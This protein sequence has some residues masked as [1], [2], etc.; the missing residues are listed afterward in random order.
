MAG[1]L[2]R[3]GLLLALVP[4]AVTIKHTAANAAA[5]QFL[6]SYAANADSN[7]LPSGLMYKILNAGTG[8]KPSAST[9]CQ[10]HYEGRLSSNYPSGPVFDSS[11]K[12]GSPS[13]FAPNQVIKGWTEAMQMMPVG[14]KWELVCP[15]EI[16]Y[17]GR[18]MGSKIPANSVLVFTMELISCKGVHSGSGAKLPGGQSVE[19]VGTEPRGYQG[20]ALGSWFALVSII[21]ACVL[22]VALCV[23]F[24]GFQGKPR[25]GHSRHGG[26]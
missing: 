8:G 19:P 18:S 12:R 23:V 5:K 4:C 26:G 7:E 17:G 16:A 22:V 1:V 25:A 20:N 14:S 10:C 24:G 13:S 15:P 9:S 6:E 21:A 2:A 3:I 11:Y